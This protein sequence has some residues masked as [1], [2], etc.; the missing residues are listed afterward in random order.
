VRGALA[1]YKIAC[2]Q[3]IL[4]LVEE[5][6]LHKGM[7]SMRYRQQACTFAARSGSC[8]RGVDNT[9][10]GRNRMVR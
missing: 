10:H 4:T 2:C 9:E 8:R 1:L 5:A 6:C 7:S 3:Q